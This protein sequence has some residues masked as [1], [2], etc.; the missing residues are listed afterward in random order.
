MR[1]VSSEQQAGCSAPLLLA[2][3]LD[4]PAAC[5]AV[6]TTLGHQRYPSSSA[7]QMAAC[8]DGAQPPPG[9]S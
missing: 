3:R 6:P 5:R 2:R 8:V 4:S 1:E 9:C 7:V